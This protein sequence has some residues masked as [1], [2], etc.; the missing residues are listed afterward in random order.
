MNSQ[1]LTNE[2]KQSV[3]DDLGIELT[4]ENAAKY[5]RDLVYYVELLATMDK[6][7]KENQTTN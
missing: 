6:E 5:L 4:D 7:S 2:F 1:G 3:L